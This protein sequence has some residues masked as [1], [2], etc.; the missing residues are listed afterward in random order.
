MSDGWSGADRMAVFSGGYAFD[1]LD[2]LRDARR[3]AGVDVID[4]G[5]GDPTEPVPEPVVQAA[6]EGLHRHRTSGYPSYVGNQTLREAAARYLERRFDVALDPGRQVTATAGSKEAVFH[7]PLAFVDPGR[8]VLVPS[9]G[10]PPY[11]AGTAI[12]G[13]QVHA[14]P[15]EAEGPC[16]PDLDAL[17]PEVA[18]RLAV[19]WIT[20]P[21]VP[22]GRFA[23][24]QALTRLVDQCRR[25]GVLL[26]SDEAYIELWHGERPPSALETGS[27][28]VLSFFSLSKQAVMTS[29]RVGFVAGD[30]RATAIFRRLKTQIDS[31]TPQF[32]QDAAA[33]ALA[34][35]DVAEASRR[36]YRERAE[37]LVEALAARG[38]GVTIPQAGFYLWAAVPD[39]GSG[40]AFARRLLEESPALAVLPGEWLASPVPDRRGTPGDGRVRLALVPSLERCYEAARRLHAW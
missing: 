38:C 36:A 4:F 8:V 15:V 40:L 29:Y 26:C 20:Q 11:A 13:G 16:L 17:P 34:L 10:Y 22:T 37:V 2:K 21:H 28:H 32:V 35:D 39:G 9:P 24:L 30:E 33:A 1:E 7:L 18:E 6:S 3:G 19:V 31:G 12:A 27:D 14:Y 25:R 23:D 5:V